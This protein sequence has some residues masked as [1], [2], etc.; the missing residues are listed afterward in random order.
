MKIEI[1]SKLIDVT[2]GMKKAYEK[3]FNFMNKYLNEDDVLDF[4]VSKKKEGIKLSVQASVPHGDYVRS[5]VY[6]EDFYVGI[7]ELK[8]QFKEDFM[9]EYKHAKDN[10]KRWRDRKNE[11]NKEYE[12]QYINCD[13]DVED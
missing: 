8:R 7:K 12:E 13:L 6:C 9:R 2:D 10:N 1:R 4:K 5:D 11:A 3:E